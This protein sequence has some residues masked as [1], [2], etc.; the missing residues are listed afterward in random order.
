MDANRSQLLSEIAQKD[1]EVVVLRVELVGAQEEALNLKLEREKKVG[2]APPD[3]RQ[4]SA[5][6]M[7]L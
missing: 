4:K 1:R 2:L 6:A 7:T 3:P 5:F